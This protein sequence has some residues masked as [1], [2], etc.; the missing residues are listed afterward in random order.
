VSTDNNKWTQMGFRGWQEKLHTMDHGW[1]RSG[2]YSTIGLFEGQSQEQNRPRGKGFTI[3]GLFH[4][5]FCYFNRLAIGHIF[6][7]FGNKNPG[8]YKKILS[9]FF[10]LSILSSLE[11]WGRAL[12]AQ[13]KHQVKHKTQRPFFL[14]I[15]THDTCS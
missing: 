7:P 3:N 12:V 8:R 10:S 1:P 2:L 13:L 5:W 9:F 14:Y 4:N 11:I 6:F 15:H